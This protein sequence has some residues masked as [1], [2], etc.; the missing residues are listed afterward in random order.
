MIYD[1]NKCVATNRIFKFKVIST[2]G[3]STARLE[4]SREKVCDEN[5]NG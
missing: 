5:Q 3:L 1:A 2:R 4:F